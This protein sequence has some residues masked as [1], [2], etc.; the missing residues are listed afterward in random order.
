[1]TATG[2]RAVATAVGTR[3]VTGTAS[4]TVGGLTATAVVQGSPGRARIGIG[5][6]AYARIGVS[7]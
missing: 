6:G 3:T 5:A 1:M 4:S 2:G 7:G